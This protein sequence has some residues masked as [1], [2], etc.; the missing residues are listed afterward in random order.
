MK[1]LT[2]ENIKKVRKRA[3]ALLIIYLLLLVFI[4]LSL[5]N[6]AMVAT[7]IFAVLS[8]AVMTGGTRI[9]SS[10]SKRLL[11]SQTEE[12]TWGNENS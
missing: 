4:A 5:F 6:D 10:Y 1:F 9:V 2:P 12:E 8:M 3:I 7:V 11:Q